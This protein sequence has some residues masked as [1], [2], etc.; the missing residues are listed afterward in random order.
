MKFSLI[1]GLL[2]DVFNGAFVFKETGV[3]VVLSII[4]SLVVV[5]LELFPLTFTL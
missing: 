5:I 2:R 3:S 1:Q 4:F